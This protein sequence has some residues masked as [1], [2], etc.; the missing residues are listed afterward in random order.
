MSML[1]R[2]SA[3]L[4]SVLTAHVSVFWWHQTVH[5]TCMTSRFKESLVVGRRILKTS[6]Q[7]THVLASWLISPP[8]ACSNKSSVPSTVGREHL[9]LGLTRCYGRRTLTGLTALRF[10]IRRGFFPGAALLH[11]LFTHRRGIFRR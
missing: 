4:A 5:A 2:P 8:L 7:K 6:R 10:N 1:L 11:N 9:L 3:W